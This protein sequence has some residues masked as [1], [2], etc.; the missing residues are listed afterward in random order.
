MAGA[1]FDSVTS[2]PAE[3]GPTGLVEAGTQGIASGLAESIIEVLISAVLALLGGCFGGILALVAAVREG[4]K[5][6]EG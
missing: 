5:R 6:A 2:V 1:H 4:R 3:T